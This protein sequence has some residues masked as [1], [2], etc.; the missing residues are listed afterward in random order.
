MKPA[1]FSLCLSLFLLT[2]AVA[3]QAPGSPDQPLRM[4]QTDASTFVGIVSDAVC[5]ARHRFKDKSPEECTRACVRNGGKF[6]LVAGE[7][8]Y[9]LKGDESELAQLAS[10]KARITGSLEGNAIQVGTARPT[11]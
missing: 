4:G 5:S 1:L 2:G 8:T 7:K 10:Q 9:I 3:E 11:Q 6:V